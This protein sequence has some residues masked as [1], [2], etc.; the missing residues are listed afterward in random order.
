MENR[1]LALENLTKTLEK[2]EMQEIVVKD[3]KETLKNTRFMMLPKLLNETM[4]DLSKENA[5]LYTLKQEYN[6]LVWNLYTF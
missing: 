5:A 2:I 3:K 1:K 6:Q 4:S